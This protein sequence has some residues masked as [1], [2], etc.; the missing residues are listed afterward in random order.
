MLLVELWGP[1]CEGLWQRLLCESFNLENNQFYVFIEW[2][3]AFFSGEKS[4]P[5]FVLIK[6]MY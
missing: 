5:H 6:R 4:D 1:V 3:Y 2:S